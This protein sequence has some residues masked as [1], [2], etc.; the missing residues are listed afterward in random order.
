MRWN[1]L[2]CATPSELN[3][4]CAF[5]PRVSLTTFAYPG[6]ELSHPFRVPST[7][8]SASILLAVVAASRRHMWVACS[9]CRYFLR[10]TPV[11]RPYHFVL[12]ASF[13]VDKPLLP[14][15]AALSCVPIH[16]ELRVCP[17]FSMQESTRD[18]AGRRA[19]RSLD[20]GQGVLFPGAGAGITW[21]GCCLILRLHDLL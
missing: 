16:P 15:P 14:S 8:R 9:S 17:G 12:F 19:V 7:N 5:I 3:R 21:C 2:I 11:S 6:L 10:S 1:V 4:C 18:V 20:K 13:V